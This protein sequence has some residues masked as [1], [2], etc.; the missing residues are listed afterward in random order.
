MDRVADCPLIEVLDLQNN[1]INWPIKPISDV[2][3]ALPP[4][5]E[6]VGHL[7]K[8]RAVRKREL[9]APSFPFILLLTLTASLE[10]N[11][12]K[13]RVFLSTL[14]SLPIL[15]QLTMLGNKAQPLPRP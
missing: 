12:D 9:E 3:D 4:L 8:A 6:V 10:A 14:A 15:T 1:H 11:K 2:E 13:F 5:D 7:E